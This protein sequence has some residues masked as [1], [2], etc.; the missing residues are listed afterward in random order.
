MRPLRAALAA[1]AALAAFACQA[2]GFDCAKA[3]SE[4]E[5]AVCANPELSRLDEQMAAAYK[6]TLARFAGDKR[7]AAEFR[8]NQADWVKERGRCGD[9]AKCLR[10]EYAARIRWLGHPAQAYAGEWTA[11]KALLNFHVQRENGLLY[12]ALWPDKSKP[13]EQQDMV[14]MSIDAAFKDAKQMDTGEDTIVIAKPQFSLR[15]AA[16][17]ASCPEIRLSF[18]TTE[19]MGLEAADGCPLLKGPEG[20]FRPSR[21]VFIYEFSR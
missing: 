5:K 7:R 2:A 1:I 17:K 21:P 12:V 15:N 3:R 16:L 11:R 19:M 6:A 14:F 9:T 4:D 13:R 18:G 8:R 20:D 10:D